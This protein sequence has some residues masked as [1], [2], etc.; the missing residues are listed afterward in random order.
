MSVSSSQ[1][2]SET[3]NWLQ[4]S[5]LTLTQLQVKLGGHLVRKQQLSVFT[6]MKIQSQS[7]HFI[8]PIFFKGSFFV[9]NKSQEAYQDGHV[10]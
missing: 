8:L 9:A 6:I 5:H 4:F 1:C 3:N 2:V 10:T 7:Q